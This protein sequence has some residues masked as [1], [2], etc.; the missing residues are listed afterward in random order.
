MRVSIE[1]KDKASGLIFK[2]HQVEV[3]V[4]V[5]FS[6]E[7]QAIIK[8]RKL[9]D[10]VITERIPDERLAGKIGSSFVQEHKHMYHLYVRDLTNGRPDHFVFDTPAHAK[11]YEQKVTEGL[12]ELKAFIAGNAEIGTTKSFEL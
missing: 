9:K 3:A 5:V 1:H 4:T 11:A 6:E 8:H 2:T 12:K 7:E 10:Y